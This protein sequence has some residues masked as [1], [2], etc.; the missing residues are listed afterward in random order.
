MAAAE[1]GNYPLA[2]TSIYLGLIRACATP[3]SDRSVLEV[4]RGVTA[5]SRIGPIAGGEGER[6]LGEGGTTA[7][8]LPACCFCADRRL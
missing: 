8:A 5:P 2:A 4:P 7:C 1:H 6:L 3:S